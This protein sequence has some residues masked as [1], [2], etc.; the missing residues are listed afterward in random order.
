MGGVSLLARAI[1]SAKVSSIDEIVVSTDSVEYQAIARLEGAT[2]HQLRPPELAD[3]YASSIDVI[4]YEVTAFE[5]AFSQNVTEVV[6]LEPTSPFRTSVHVEAAFEIYKSGKFDSL[7]SVCNL[8]RKPENIFVKRGTLSQ[9]ITSNKD[10]FTRRQ[11][12]AHLCR[13]NSAIYI[14][15]KKEMFRTRKIT[16]G[17]IGWFDMDERSSINIDTELELNFANYLAA[18]DQ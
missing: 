16:F 9:Y 7:V 8:E 11:D 5:Q 4:L 6:L 18:S 10:A 13:L 15:D 17:R 2:C 3:D 1:H 12:M 14:A